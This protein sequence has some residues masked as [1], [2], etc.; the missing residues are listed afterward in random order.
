M[1]TEMNP[2]FS[3]TVVQIADDAVEAFKASGWT[4]AKSSARKSADKK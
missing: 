3:D 2:P 1:A 4:E